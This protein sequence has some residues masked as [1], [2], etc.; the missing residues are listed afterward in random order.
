[1]KYGTEFL[2]KKVTEYHNFRET[3]RSDSHTVYLRAQ[4]N[5]YPLFPC[6]LAALG[7]IRKD[8]PRMTLFITCEFHENQ[9]CGSRTSATPELS[10]CTAHLVSQQIFMAP[11]D[12]NK[13]LTLPFI[14][15]IRSKQL[16][17]YLF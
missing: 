5:L 12:Q 13:Y 4:I 3:R 11:L 15:V 6:A 7:K 10:W 9:F 14:G 1:M 8:E 16:N 17:N 2:L